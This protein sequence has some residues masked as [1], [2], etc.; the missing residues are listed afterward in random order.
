MLE[1]LAAIPNNATKNK[2]LDALLS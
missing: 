1:H 2:I